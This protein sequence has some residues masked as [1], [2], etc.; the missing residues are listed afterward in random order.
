MSPFLML[1]QLQHL[2]RDIGKPY[3]QG[4]YSWS[5]LPPNPPYESSWGYK[6]ADF[7]FLPYIL[8]INAFTALECIKRV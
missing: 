5:D 6:I 2:L 3:V 4:L 8:F 1:L 7:V